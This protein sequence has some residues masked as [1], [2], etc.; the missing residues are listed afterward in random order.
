[1]SEEEKIFTKSDLMEKLKEVALK[2]KERNDAQIAKM[3]EEYDLLQS[4]VE[5]YKAQ[6]EEM[7]KQ[8]EARVKKMKEEYDLLQ[9]DV[10]SY[11]AQFEEMQKKINDLEEENAKLSSKPTPSFEDRKLELIEAING[12]VLDFFANG[13]SQPQEKDEKLDPNIWKGQKTEKKADKKSEKKQKRAE[14]EQASLLP[15]QGAKPE[16]ALGSQ[17]EKAEDSRSS[18]ETSDETVLDIN[19]LL[20]SL[21]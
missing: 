5:S 13:S 19:E 6:F 7:Q 20:N 12:V 4:D 11:K 10:D 16:E 9:S 8:S 21:N 17:E 3:K 18:E 14:Q 15:E 1:M 2:Q